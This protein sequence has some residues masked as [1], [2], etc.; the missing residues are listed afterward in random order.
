VLPVEKV[1]EDPS[2]EID[3]ETFENMPDVT[4]TNSGDRKP[5]VPEKFSLPE[6]ST[7]IYSADGKT[8]ISRTVVQQQ[9]DNLAGIPIECD[10][11]S[12]LNPYTTFVVFN[13]TFPKD[14]LEEANLLNLYL[15]AKLISRAYAMSQ[16]GIE[17]I[18]EMMEAV[19]ADTEKDTQ[20]QIAINNAMTGMGEVPTDPS[21]DPSLEEEDTSGTGEE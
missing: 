5:E 18:Q 9:R 17:N 21:T 12:Y 20:Q 1:M 6:V 15:Q 7:A 10:A 19:D 13:N 11:H 4:R 16:I 14:K 2:I 3:G 8:L